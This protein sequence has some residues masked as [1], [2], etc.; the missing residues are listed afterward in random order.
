MIQE[1]QQPDQHIQRW[2]T[3]ILKSL[4]GSAGTT[5]PPVPTDQPGGLSQS[6]DQ[7]LKMLI[8]EIKNSEKF[9][10]TIPKVAAF[11]KEHPQVNIDHYLKDCSKTFTGF[12]KQHLEKFSY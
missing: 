1:H 8:E 7:S 6:K 4:P 11:L 12:V 10:A 2:I 5:A 3:I 9:E